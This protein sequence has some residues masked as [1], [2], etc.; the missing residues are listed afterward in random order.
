MGKR[1]ATGGKAFGSD[2]GGLIFVKCSEKSKDQ[3]MMKMSHIQLR[4]KLLFSCRA[5]RITA[6]HSPA[7][8]TP[9]RGYCLPAG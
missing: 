1:T 4:I 7:L 9:V 5:I 2:D 3:E 6:L 8:E